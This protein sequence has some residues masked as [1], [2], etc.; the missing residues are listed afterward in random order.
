MACDLALRALDDGL[1]RVMASV[2]QPCVG[3]L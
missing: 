3:R 2:L 1:G